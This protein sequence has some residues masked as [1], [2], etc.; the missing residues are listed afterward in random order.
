MQL[1]GTQGRPGLLA[2][3]LVFCETSARVGVSS[4]SSMSFQPIKEKLPQIIQGGMGIG[5]SGWSLA[6]AVSRL[7]QLGVVSG[8]ALDFVM[9]RRLQLGDKGG[10]VRRALKA[11]PQS[12]MVDRILDKYFRPDGKPEKTPFKNPMTLLAK[13]KQELQELLVTS[14]FVEVFLAKE[15][16]KGNV[17][18]NYLEKIQMATLPSLYGAMLA[19]VSFVLMGAGIPRDIPGVMD[20]LAQHQ[21]VKI[22]ISVDDLKEQESYF[23]EFSPEVFWG[24]VPE[25]IPR[26]SFLP[27]ISSN[28][29]ALS[30]AKKATGSIQGF[31]VEGHVAGGH[32]APPRGAFAKNEQG[33]P[34][35]GDKDRPNLEKIRAL[36][37]PFWMAGGYG[38]AEGLAAALDFGA[39]GVQV[40]TAFAL[41]EESSLDPAF[42]RQILEASQKGTLEVL[43]DPKASPTGFPFKVAQL[44][45]SLSDSATYQDRNRICDVGYLRR[46]YLTKQG[47]LG[48]RCPAEPQEQFLAK[49]GDLAHTE[50]RKCLCNALLANVGLGQVQ[51]QGYQEKPLL[52]LGSELKELSHFIRN[53]RLSFTA[54]DVVR[55]LLN[56]STT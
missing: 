34:V 21:N 22:P 23:V 31:I 38:S 10:H 41:C 44:E 24:G 35:Y 39:A 9:V 30:L 33:E 14:N 2:L 25:A 55:D 28:A 27:I 18:I 43:T 6:R 47:R 20:R 5:V 4:P 17:G 37:Y 48:Y 12:D 16:H 13:M 11:F 36:G 19:G 54:E 50:G 15:N 46:P 51:A 49:G 8:S 45:N 7:G 56:T 26:P 53:G 40:G 29:L 52:T 3:R 1:V 32:N 42:K